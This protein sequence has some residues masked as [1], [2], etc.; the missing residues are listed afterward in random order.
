MRSANEYGPGE[1][2]IGLPLVH[3]L[4]RA[5]NVLLERTFRGVRSR[6]ADKLLAKQAGLAGGSIAISVAFNQPWVIELTTRM[7]K[8]H[9][10]GTLIVLD[11]SRDANA[12]NEIARICADRDVP[13]LA[14]PFNPERHPCR[15][16][17]IAMT[18]GYYNIVRELR[19]RVFTFLD[20]DLIPTVPFDPA[21]LV[22]HQPVYGILNHSAW[23]WNLWA[24]YCIY[25]FASVE[26]YAL[27]FNN[28]NPRLLD[29][30]GRNWLQIYRYLDRSKIRFAEWRQEW[31]RDPG[32]G[33]RRQAYF[34]DGMVHVG[35]A[36]FGDKSYPPTK[37]EFFQRLVRSFED[38]ATIEQ[39]RY[40]A[41]NEQPV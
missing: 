18:W 23:G 40:P 7:A 28:D 41:S 2:L 3:G 10:D 11:N 17:G 1:W 15:S 35:G 39:L 37:P 26:R 31:V 36:G 24:G 9:L 34:V 32:D 20:H 27:D 6:E 22:E 5:R 13:Y 21:R 29:T 33:I 16:H 14:L 19:P 25:D 30:G 8:R 38:G 4:K 12:R